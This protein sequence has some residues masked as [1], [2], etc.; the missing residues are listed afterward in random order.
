MLLFKSLYPNQLNNEVGST[1]QRTLMLC[2]RVILVQESCQSTQNT[3]IISGGS[4]PI[5]IAKHS[6]VKHHY[7]NHHYHCKSNHYHCKSNHY[8]CKSNHHNHYHHTTLSHQQTPHQSSNIETDRF[9][10]NATNSTRKSRL[11]LATIFSFSYMLS[12]TSSLTTSPASLCRSGITI[13]FRS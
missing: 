8:H 2:N 13:L 6:I 12:I 11:F 10:N 4:N 5:T 7:C 9:G 1:P 3:I